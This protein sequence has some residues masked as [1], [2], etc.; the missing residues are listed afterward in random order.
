MKSTRLHRPNRV[1]TSGSDHSYH[2]VPLL[3]FSSDGKKLASLDDRGVITLWDVPNEARLGKC[4]E[5]PG[6]PYCLAFAPNGQTLVSVRNNQVT[7]WDATGLTE[8]HSWPF[9]G[10][11]HSVAFDDTGRRLATGNA[12]GTAYVL[13]LTSYLKPPKR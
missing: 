10:P 13:D 2:R 12:N 11:V 7:L 5:R 3:S 4:K 6:I 8:L 1:P 9:P